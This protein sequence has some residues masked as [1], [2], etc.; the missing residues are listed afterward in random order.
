MKRM[1]LLFA[2]L[3]VGGVAYVNAQQAVDKN[4]FGLWQYVEECEG[5]QIW[6][7]LQVLYINQPPTT[8]YSVR[9]RQKTNVKICG[10]R[11][12]PCRFLPLS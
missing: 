11:I 6:N 7:Y 9:Q 4:L 8:I 10:R 5:P 3:L 12:S 1:M 2:A